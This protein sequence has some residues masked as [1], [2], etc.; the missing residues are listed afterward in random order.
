MR[1]FWIASVYAKWASWELRRTMKNDWG[2]DIPSSGDPFE[3]YM[4]IHVY[5][6]IYIQSIKIYTCMY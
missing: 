4:D 1:P 6:Y 5:I 3:P 2:Y